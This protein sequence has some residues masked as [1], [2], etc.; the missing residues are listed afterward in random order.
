LKRGKVGLPVFVLEADQGEFELI[1]ELDELRVLVRDSWEVLESEFRFWDREGYPITFEE[2]F[3]KNDSDPV[4]LTGDR[5]E[6]ELIK[7]FLSRF[8]KKIDFPFEQ[9]E[10]LDLIGLFR[11]VKEHQ[12]THQLDGPIT[13]YFNKRLLLPI[14]VLIVFF[15]LLYFFIVLR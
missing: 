11:A 8:G 4:V 5:T 2:S 15:N 6:L 1:D 3:L 10:N 13:Y 14:A 12:K 7:N 9:Y